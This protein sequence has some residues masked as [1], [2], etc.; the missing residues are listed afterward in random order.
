VKDAF[1]DV[2]SARRRRLELRA[3]LHRD[4]RKRAEIEHLEALMRFRPRI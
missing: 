1:A 2:K 3:E 4:H